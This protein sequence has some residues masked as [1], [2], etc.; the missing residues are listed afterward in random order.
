MKRAA[1]RIDSRCADVIRGERHVGDQEGALHA[2]AHGARVMQHLLHGDG[3]SVFVAQHDHAQR[4]ADQHHV[5]AGFVDQ[6]RAGIVICGETGNE[7]VTL[8]LVEEGGSG[9]FGRGSRRW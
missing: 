8:F 2:A 6:P 9:D 5:D 3:Q 1:L 7:F 4:I